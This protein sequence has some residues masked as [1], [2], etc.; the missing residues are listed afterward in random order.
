MNE[1]KLSRAATLNQALLGRQPETW[2]FRY[3]SS[4][5]LFYLKSCTLK[6]KKIKINLGRENSGVRDKI[7][8]RTYFCQGTNP[9]HNLGM[10]TSGVRDRSASRTCFCHRTNPKHN[11]R[12]L[13]SGVCDRSASRTFSL[14]VMDASGNAEKNPKACPRQ[15]RVAD[16]VSFR[17]FFI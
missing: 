8:S 14:H 13:T 12:K 9:K 6:Q 4:C 16:L 15:L 17:V 2:C 7:A 5:I 1:K 10:L 11:L 3:Y